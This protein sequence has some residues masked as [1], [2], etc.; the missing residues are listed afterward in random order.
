MSPHVTPCRVGFTS[1]KQRLRNLTIARFRHHEGL[2]DVYQYV[3]DEEETKPVAVET[4]KKAGPKVISLDDPKS[5][6]ESS[7]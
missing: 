2:G 4:P 3:V 6:P 1:V 5:K 7:S